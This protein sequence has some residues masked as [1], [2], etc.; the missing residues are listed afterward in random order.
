MPRFNGGT[1]RRVPPYR[2]F[3]LWPTTP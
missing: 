3:K 2:L 1:D